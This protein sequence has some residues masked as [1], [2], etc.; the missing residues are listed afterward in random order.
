MESQKIERIY[1]RLSGFSIDLPRDPTSMGPE[2][3]REAISLCRNYLNETAHYLQDV[4]VEES[5]L[6]MRLDS[7]EAAYQI[8]STELL[9]TDPRVTTRPNIAD[10]QAAIDN[11]LKD[12]KASIIRLQSD[13]RSLGHVKTVVRNRQTELN[14]TMSSIRLQRSLLKDA[15]RT[16][17]FYGDESPLSRG[18]AGADPVDTLDTVDLEALVTA[19]EAELDAEARAS[20]KSP[21][22]LDETVFE[23]LVQSSAEVAEVAPQP[24]EISDEQALERFL[25]EPDEDV[26]SLLENV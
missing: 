22:E 3:L 13:I 5:F 6:L 18:H 7:E 14:N 9:A 10:R 26:A 15:L 20:S 11:I 17:A 21:D 8:R 16:G 4:L 24:E 12:Q 19:A 2:Y 23:Q 1:E 25:Q